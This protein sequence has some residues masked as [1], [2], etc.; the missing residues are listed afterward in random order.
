MT[1][2]KQIE[3]NRRNAKLSTGPTTAAGQA[4]SSKNALKHGLTA[5]AVTL[6]GDEAKRLAAFR[7][8]IIR[9]LAPVGPLE[10]ELAQH[11]ALL[12]WRRR[13]VAWLEV[14]ETRCFSDGNCDKHAPVRDFMSDG[15]KNLMRYE[16]F[17]DR[18]LERTIL[19]LAQLKA[20][21]KKDADLPLSIFAEI[22]GIPVT[23]Q[24]EERPCTA[25][26]LER[27]AAKLKE[28][29]EREK[30]AASAADD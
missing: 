30:A 4:R 13:R 19:A 9:E 22:N 2:K 23:I 17:L 6:D 16:S 20:G 24:A 11:A 14:T 18:S 28:E 25:E 5:E 8:D 29:L 10:E 15:F 3:A 26:E 27:A 1:T 7:D 12:F 21:R